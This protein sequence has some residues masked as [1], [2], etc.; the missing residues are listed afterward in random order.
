[1]HAKGVPLEDITFLKFRTVHNTLEHREDIATIF[2]EVSLTLGLHVGLQDGQK[3][4]QEK[5]P[6]TDGPTNGPDRK[7]PLPSETDIA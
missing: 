2:Y 4:R 1:M 6:E 5:V 3:K 7:Q